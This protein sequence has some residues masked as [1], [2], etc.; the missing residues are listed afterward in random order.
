MNPETRDKRCRRV[1]ELRVGSRRR[2]AELASATGFSEANETERECWF[3]VGRP[4][5][6]VRNAT[7]QTGRDGRP[8][9]EFDHRLF[10]EAGVDRTRRENEAEIG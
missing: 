7:D 9:G 4:S 8:T 10:S 2:W 1:V 3:P 5:L 6:P